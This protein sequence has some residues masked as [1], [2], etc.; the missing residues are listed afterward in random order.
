MLYLQGPTASLVCCVSIAK[1]YSLTIFE[2]AWIHS[3]LHRMLID[4]WTILIIFHMIK[5]CAVYIYTVYIFGKKCFRKYTAMHLLRVRFFFLS[6]SWSGIWGFSGSC[7]RPN[8]VCLFHA[9]GVEFLL[10]MQ[11]ERR[12]GVAGRAKTAAASHQETDWAHSI[13]RNNHIMLGSEHGIGNIILCQYP[14]SDLKKW[15][16]F[17]LW[18]HWSTSQCVQLPSSVFSGI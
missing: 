4:L 14:I 5:Y 6:G 11:W 2:S 8:G 9:L 13:L 15:P 7:R 12:S 17:F 1:L 10:L 18:A 16:T 3:I